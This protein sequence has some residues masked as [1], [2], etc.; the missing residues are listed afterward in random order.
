MFRTVSG[1]T[2]A[3]TDAS[4]NMSPPACNP[5]WSW[6]FGDGAG[7]SSQKDPTYTFQANKTYQVQLT[8]S[9]VIG[10]STITKDVKP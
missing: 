5:I 3:F 7:S 8:V 6:N 10:S 2:V 9:N 4:T 1:K